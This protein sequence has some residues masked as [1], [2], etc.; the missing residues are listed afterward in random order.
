[1]KY[2]IY[3]G[4]NLIDD[5]NIR[6]GYSYTLDVQISGANSGD[7]RVTITDGGVVVF[8]EIDHINMT[9]DF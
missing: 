1:M 2:R 5:Y 9:V 7:V 3:P 8:D 6:R 4:T